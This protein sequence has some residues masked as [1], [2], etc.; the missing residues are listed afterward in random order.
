MGALIMSN[1][2]KIPEISQ[3][4]LRRFAKQIKPV[5]TIKGTQY[6]HA[7]C[8]VVT[9][10]FAGGIDK[11]LPAEALEEY[12]T[13]TTYHRYG[14]P[15]LFK[16]SVEEV[17]AQIPDQMLEQ[18]TGFESDLISMD[19]NSCVD[20][21]Y[22]VAS[23]RFY[24]GK[25]PLEAQKQDVTIRG[26]CYKGGVDERVDDSTLST[27]F[28]KQTSRTELQKSTAN[29]RQIKFNSRRRPKP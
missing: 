3:D 29:G 18:I 21:D 15:M 22:H 19:P 13:M 4:D 6:V 7:P 27:K 5:T 8:D 1:G 25:L 23:T 24:M 17:L 28:K 11:N 12:F 20:G 9:Q 26:K 10:S 14:H 16:P 2:D